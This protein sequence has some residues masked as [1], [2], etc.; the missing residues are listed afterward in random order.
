MAGRLLVQIWSPVVFISIL[1]LVMAGAA[2]WGLQRTQA[3]SAKILAANVASLHAAREFETSLYEARLALNECL[4]AGDRR[5][6]ADLP[7]LRANLD[8]SMTEVV[9]TASTPDCR[10]QVA[11]LKKGQERCATGLLHIELETSLANARPK[12]RE[13]SHDLL[14]G[15]L[16]PLAHQYILFNE[17]EITRG[18]QASQVFANWLAYGFLAVGTLAS[19]LGL[20]FG[21]G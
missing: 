11:K 18:S 2:A 13:I 3:D 5:S 15:E 8:R 19:M 9:A 7:A 12:I 4:A 14:S 10:E 6:L 21:F 20:L 16:I 17:Q 1:L